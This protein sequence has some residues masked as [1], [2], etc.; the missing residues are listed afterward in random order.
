MAVLYFDNYR[1]FRLYYPITKIIIRKNRNAQ[2]V[3][4]KRFHNISVSFFNFFFFLPRLRDGKL[5]S[6]RISV[7]SFRITS[8]SHCLRDFKRDTE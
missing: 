5:R 4:D 8:T 2:E 7:L 3:E 1:H 6:R